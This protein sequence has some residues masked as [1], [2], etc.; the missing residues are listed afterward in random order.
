MLYRTRSQTKVLPA[1]E[2]SPTAKLSHNA[3][4]PKPIGH[5]GTASPTEQ[6]EEAR[7]VFQEKYKCPARPL[8]IDVV[9]SLLNK[10]TTFLIAGTGYGKSRIPELYRNLYSD[11]IVLIICPLEAL[12][13]DQVLEKTSVNESAINLTSNSI[14]KE[15]ISDI[16][17]GKYHYVY[18]AWMDPI[19]YNRTR[20]PGRCDC[21]NCSPEEAEAI[22]LLQPHITNEAIDKVL[23]MDLAE[24][25]TMLDEAPTGMN[26]QGGSNGWV[27]KRSFLD[28][29]NGTFTEPCDIRHDDLFPS[30]LA[31]EII[32]NIDHL[33]EPGFL[34]QIL[35]S[36]VIKHQFQVLLKTSKSHL[37]IERS[38]HTAQNGSTTVKDHPNRRSKLKRWVPQ[39][40]EGA[41]LDKGQAEAKKAAK[42]L[43][44]EAVKLRKAAMKAQKKHDKDLSG[45]MKQKASLNKR[46]IV[47]QSNDGKD[48]R[49][50]KRAKNPKDV[51][52]SF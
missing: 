23:A 35:G 24:L 9:V 38:G 13:D 27:P 2:G 4:L 18:V 52:C 20:V 26:V 51:I 44:D 43:N 36:E 19:G 45:A 3:V 34:E 11:G 39:S 50:T 5:I 15:A 48:S 8:Q 17:N 47:D 33:E 31:W 14:S 6:S 16:L 29:F 25:T 32:K 1:I 41:K 30:F 37:T 46:A 12:G 22:W 42:K 40:V 28:L 10:K 49:V 21:S 7:R